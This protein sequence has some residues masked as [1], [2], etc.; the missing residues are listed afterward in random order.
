MV[1][2]ALI[3]QNCG[4]T[5]MTRTDGFLI[6]GHCRAKYTDEQYKKLVID[7]SLNVI[8]KHRIDN[9]DKFDTHIQNARRALKN[10]DW[11]GVTHY[12]VAVR[13]IKPDCLEVLIF[14]PFARL[15]L[16]QNSMDFD[17]RYSAVNVFLNSINAISEL[18]SGSPEDE[19]VITLFADILDKLRRFKFIQYKGNDKYGR[20]QV[21][22]GTLNQ[23]YAEIIIAFIWELRQITDKDYSETLMRLIIRE[24]NLLFDIK[25]A[26]FKTRVFNKLII[27]AHNKIRENNPNYLIPQKTKRYSRRQVSFFV[28]LIVFGVFALGIFVCYALEIF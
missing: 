26:K 14:E 11:N 20:Q 24:C 21:Y 16:T 27:H 9:T 17:L 13:D 1:K 15:M 10:E 8:H 6:C 25:K 7:G 19:A 2:E 12:C 4:S 22:K 3:C 23:I 5:E 18:W 28:K